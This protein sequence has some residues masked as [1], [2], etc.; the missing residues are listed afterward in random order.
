MGVGINGGAVGGKGE[1]GKVRVGDSPPAVGLWVGLGLG[2][3]ENGNVELA[4]EQ[5]QRTK[6]AMMIR[7]ES[8]IRL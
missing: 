5:S 6:V 7:L 8:K 4:G 2:L 1:A 3:A